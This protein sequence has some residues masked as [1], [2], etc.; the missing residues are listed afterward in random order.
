MTAVTRPRPS[1]TPSPA[2]APVREEDERVFLY[3]VPWEVYEA[4]D[5]VRGDSARPRMTY[6]DGEL[7]LMSPGQPHET[8]KKLIA[9][10]VEAYADELAL[11]L[12]GTGSWTIKKRRKKRG[13]EADESYILGDV[14]GRKEPDLVIEVIYT[15]GGIDKLEVWRGLGVREVWLWEDGEVRVHE[16]VGAGYER[17]ERSVMF[18]DLDLAKLASFV[19]R[20]DQ[21]QAVREFRAW[22]RKPAKKKPARKVRRPRRGA[23]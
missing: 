17:R 7:E 23:T 21:S 6:L 3:G 20:P 15:S 10:L 16:L 22:L 1:L 11:T 9:R 18:P 19:G 13:A 14:K 8:T 12:T 5:A 4:L 2:P